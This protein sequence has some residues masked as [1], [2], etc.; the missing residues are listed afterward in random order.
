MKKIVKWLLAAGAV[1]AALLV[2]AAIIIP[3]VYDIKQHKP[4]FEETISKVTGRAF[5]IGDDMELS[6]FPWVV[7]Q[8]TDIRLGNPDGFADQDMLAAKNF[9]FRLKLLPL[10]SKKIEVKTFLLDSPVINLE[11]QKDGK[12]NWEGIG[13]QKKTES[14]PEKKKDSSA[15]GPLPIES[16][17]VESFSIV[18]G[19]FVY[20]D[21]ISGMK[22]EVSDFSLKL[23]DISFDKPVSIF[24]GA[25]IDGKPFSLEGNAGP[26][27]PEPGKGDISLDFVLNLLNELTVNLQGTLVDPLTAQQFDMRVDV[28]TFSPRKIMSELGLEMPVKTSDPTVLNAVSFAVH[29]KGSPKKISLTKG[30]IGLDDSGFDFSASAQQFSKPDLIFD[31]ALDNIDLDR[32]LPEKQKDKKKKP[33]TST[34]NKKKP[35]KQK[36][37]YTPLRKL[38]LDGKMKAGKVKASGALAE[39]IQ[40][41][42]KA[43]NGVINV[44]PCRMDLYKGALDTKLGLDVRKDTPKVG[45]NLKA[46]GIQ[47]G[48]LLKDAMQKEIIEGVF[49]ADVSLSM[50]GEDPERIKKTLNGKGDVIFNDGAIIGIDLA[51]M[52]RN[53]QTSFGAAQVG[54]EK[55]RTDFAELKIPFKIKNGLVNTANSHL[56]S[57]LLRVAVNGNV[58]L[59]KESIDLRVEPKIVATIKGQGDIKQRSGLAVPVLITGTFSSPEFAPDLVGIIKNR[60]IGDFDKDALK[61]SILGEQAGG[62]KETDKDIL[63][64]TK[65]GVEKQIK[66]L[67][68]GFFLR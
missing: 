12:A 57:P 38:V 45:V 35:K 63:E 66:E 59:V 33:G 7:V 25:K 9:E 34:A 67:I 65:D 4:F 22:K 37:D 26:I 51:G 20:S 68:P 31:I 32:Y 36:T 17:L 5:T 6:V 47:V 28:P 60:G 56:V 64:N 11:K 18:N 48:P 16:L 13:Q 46:D 58:N 50:R 62:S 29:A 54:E 61:S 24:M 43:R 49:K 2:A 1:F 10:L 8:L 55:P 44:E 15:P 19:R 27:G 53:V 39:N 21:Q 30:R 40:V 23:M 52:V 42:I 3:L 14:A 41:H